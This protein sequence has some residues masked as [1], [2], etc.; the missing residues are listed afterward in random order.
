MTT[1]LTAM[2]YKPTGG[3]GQERLF[4]QRLTINKW[5]GVVKCRFYYYL[6]MVRPTDQ[7]TIATERIVCYTHRSQ[8]EGRGTLH[9]ATWGSTRAFTALYMGRKR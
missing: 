6:G 5:L 3:A 2:I 1:I 8:E 4:W 7:E 9:R